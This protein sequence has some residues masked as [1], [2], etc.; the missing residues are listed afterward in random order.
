MSLCDLD[1]NRPIMTV[2]QVSRT[3]KKTFVFIGNYPSGTRQLFD[4]IVVGKKLTNYD[5]K[6]L[7]VQYH[8]SLQN[9][10]KVCKTCRKSAKLADYL[11]FP[12]GMLQLI[13]V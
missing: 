8:K 13:Y 2:H 9:L 1:V 12:W 11:K 5:I 3:D 10:Q 4:K 7:C 6:R